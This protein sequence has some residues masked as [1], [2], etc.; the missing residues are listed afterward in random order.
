MMPKSKGLGE[1]GPSSSS[2]QSSDSGNHY[3]NFDDKDRIKSSEN[4]KSQPKHGEALSKQERTL[5]IH[6][7]NKHLSHNYPQSGRPTGNQY[8][9]YNANSWKY[10][11][12]EENTPSLPSNTSQPDVEMKAMTLKQA[13]GSGFQ[14]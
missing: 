12:D 11:E 10:D 5:A 13:A 7:H 8:F 6:Q 1:D 3:I 9:A 2:E 4:D 14:T